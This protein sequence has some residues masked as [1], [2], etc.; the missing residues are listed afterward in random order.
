MIDP[1]LLGAALN[2]MLVNA[3]EAM[4][5]GGSVEISAANINDITAET[6]LSLPPG[7]YVRIRVRDRGEGIPAQDLEKIFDP[8]FTTRLEGTGLG[9]AVCHSVVNRHNGMITAQS[10]PEQGTTFTVYL[11]A[12]P[13]AVVPNEDEE[14]EA[15]K[16][17][18]TVLMMDDDAMVRE[19][20][21][22]ML[23]WLGYNGIETSDGS[24]AVARYRECME[25]NQPVAAV[26]LDLTVAGGMGGREACERILA[27]DPSARLIVASGYS[28]DPVM[29][30]FR[31]YGFQAFI[32]K[33]FSINELAAVLAEVIPAAAG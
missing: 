12:L 22:Q 2:N 16:G 28:N 33:P 31:D 20:T 19:I 27:L 30:D 7:S 15:V 26:I 32:S 13:G 4:P 1:E 8:Y 11:P 14:Q 18:G 24:E 17:Q 21:L 25:K 29:A 3:L 9:L 5:D 10:S 23:N 6:H